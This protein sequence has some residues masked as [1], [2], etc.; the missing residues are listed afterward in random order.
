MRAV[1]A[2]FASSVSV[3]LDEGPIRAAGVTRIKCSFMARRISTCF[4][5]TLCLRQAGRRG[6][7]LVQ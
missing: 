2:W 3:S 1:W 5:Y 4:R 7:P 6:R